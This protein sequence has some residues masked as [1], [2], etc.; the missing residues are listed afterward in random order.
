MRID[1][2]LCAMLQRYHPLFINTHFNHPKELTP[3]ARAACARLVDAGIPVGNQAV[4]LRGMN[5]SARVLR[6]LFTRAAAL[7]A[8]SPYYL[9]QG[10]TRSAPTCAR[11][12]RPRSR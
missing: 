2:E 3:E 9:F 6:A 1:D 10:D 7:R 12:S 5:S 4:L 8:S 11:P